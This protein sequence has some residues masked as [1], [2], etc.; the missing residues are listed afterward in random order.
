MKNEKPQIS[1]SMRS[2]ATKRDRIITYAKEQQ[3]TNSHVLSN[4]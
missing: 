4:M 3:T 2:V 1:I